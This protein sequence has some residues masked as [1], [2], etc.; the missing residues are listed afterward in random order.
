VSA[1]IPDPKAGGHRWEPACVECYAGYRGDESPRAIVLAG[2]RLP[3]AAVISRK[4]LRDAATGRS[5]EI[6]E[7]LLEAG[8]TVSL[9]RSEDGS[10]RVRKNVI[11]PRVDLN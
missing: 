10:W 9:E 2:V 3:V 6:F 4:R 7:C 11:V 5:V 1:S 8:W